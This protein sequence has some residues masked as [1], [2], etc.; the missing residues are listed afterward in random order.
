MNSPFEVSQFDADHADHGNY[1][2]T[3]F[4][5]RSIGEI[6][7]EAKHLSDDQV[8][9]I[10]RYQRQHAVRFGEAAVALQ[11]VDT[12]DVLWALSQ[13][14]HYPYAAQSNVRLNDELVAAVD[15]F[16]DQAEAFRELRSQL[17]QAV[18]APELPRR[19]LAVLSPQSGDGKTFF[20][21][22]LAVTLSQLGGRTLLVDA[23]MRTPRLHDLF[24]IAGS[25]GLSSY[26]SGRSRSNVV[27]QVPDLPS[28]FVLPVGT[29]PPNPLELV[30]SPAFGL[31]IHR[32]LNKFDHVV[33]DTPA[34]SHGADARVI[35]AHCGAALVLGRRGTTRMSALQSVVTALGKGPSKLVGVVMNEY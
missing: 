28:L 4:L 14:F 30:Q 32:L 10:V 20:A 13:Q 21:A 26:L 31:L 17:L 15:P 25:V 12:D 8:E 9:Q 29:V 3:Q 22:N 33:V 7:R 23:D 24:A 18:L 5:D 34:V 1:A 2:P 16:S 6:L 27:H 35:A 19:A 11:L